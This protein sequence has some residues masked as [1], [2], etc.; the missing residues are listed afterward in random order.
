MILL[1]SAC[2]VAIIKRLWISHIWQY[3]TRVFNA[4]VLVK[5]VLYPAEDGIVQ[6][7][8]TM[9]CVRHVIGLFRMDRAQKI[10]TISKR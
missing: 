8:P 2:R 9:I 3:Y 4:M 1:T 10:F 6:H 7:V 5:E